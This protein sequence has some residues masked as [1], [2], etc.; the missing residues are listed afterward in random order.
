V[1][2]FLFEEFGVCFCER[3]RKKKKKK[4]GGGKEPTNVAVMSLKR[5]QKS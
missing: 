4:R 5:K 3:R 2:D 1:L